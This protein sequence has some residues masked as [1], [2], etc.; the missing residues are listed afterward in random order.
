MNRPPRPAFSSATTRSIRLLPVFSASAGESFLACWATRWASARLSRSSSRARR[1]K[2]SSGPEAAAPIGGDACPYA[3]I[4][5][6]LAVEGL[7]Q[8]GLPAVGHFD[9]GG[10]AAK[11]D[12]ADPLAIEPADAIEE[13]QDLGLAG[14]AGQGFDV[15]KWHGLL[16]IDSSRVPP[17]FGSA[18]SKGLMGPIGLIGTILRVIEKYFKVVG[19]HRSGEL[20]PPYGGGG[21]GGRCRWWRRS[22]VEAVSAVPVVSAVSVVAAAAVAAASA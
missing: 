5:E 3:A 11:L 18:T 13:V 16:R 15:Q 22:V 12:P 20:V 21:G 6:H 8:P 9:D 14:A 19:R 7:Q 17:G 4:A 2:W 1:A 10:R